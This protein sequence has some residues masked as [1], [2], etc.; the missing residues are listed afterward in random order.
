MLDSGK[1]GKA[2]KTDQWVEVLVTEPDNLS[3]IPGT[4]HGRR[5]KPTPT[6]C[7]LESK[8]VLQVCICPH[9]HKTNAQ[10][11]KC[12]KKTQLHEIYSM[13]IHH[14]KHGVSLYI[15]ANIHV[16]TLAP[17]RHF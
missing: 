9:S 2:E 14:V 5:R 8:E 3:S 17:F 4:P 15:I 7:P 10:M 12:K 11:N 6:T 13:L 16:I 1:Q